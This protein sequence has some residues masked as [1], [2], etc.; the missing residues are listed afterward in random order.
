[1]TLRTQETLV[2]Q[3]GYRG[4]LKCSEND[5]PHSRMWESYS[6]EGFKGSG[7][8]ITDNRNRPNDLLATMKPMCPECG[9]VGSV[10]ILP[11]V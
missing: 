1:M 2:C 8:T 9:E 5:Q 4:H 6:L 7:L 10:R 11:R 3:C